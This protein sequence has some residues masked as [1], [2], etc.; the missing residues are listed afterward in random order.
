MVDDLLATGGT[1]AVACKLVHR[2]GGRI[3]GVAFVI[4]LSFLNGLEKLA[5]FEVSTLIRVEGQ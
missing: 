4:E 2:L 5:D 3:V 1:M